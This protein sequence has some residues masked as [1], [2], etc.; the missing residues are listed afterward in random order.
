M[1]AWSFG[2]QEWAALAQLTKLTRLHIDVNTA[3]S[4][5]LSDGYYTVLKGAKDCAQLALGCGTLTATCRCYKASH[6]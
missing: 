2:P 1:E 6:S 4:G 5:W 3:E